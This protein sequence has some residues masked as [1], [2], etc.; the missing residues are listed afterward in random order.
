[1]ASNGCSIMPMGG[2]TTG[3]IVVNVE[4]LR[5]PRSNDMTINHAITFDQDTE[6][7]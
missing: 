5:E 4:R 2:V 7:G 6:R 3:Y 1:M